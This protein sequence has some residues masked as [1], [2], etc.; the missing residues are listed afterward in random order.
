M[1]LLPQHHTVVV[2]LRLVKRI[3]M[4][5]AMSTD[6]H[7]QV[8]ATRTNHQMTHRCEGVGMQF[9]EDLVS[10]LHGAL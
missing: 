5:Y 10:S 7:M 6:D 4:G 2:D 8:T 1:Y 3:G 9:P